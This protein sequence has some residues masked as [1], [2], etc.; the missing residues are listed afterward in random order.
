[1]KDA[2]S[3]RRR[4]P[5]KKK[6]KVAPV[7]Q[8]RGKMDKLKELDIWCEAQISLMEES[9]ESKLVSKRRKERIKNQIIGID[10]V[11]ARIKRMML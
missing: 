3:S 11:R 10:K 9:L 8:K 2:I 1:M 6:S 5:K 4:K 7:Q